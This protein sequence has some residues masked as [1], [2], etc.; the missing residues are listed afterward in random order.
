[1]V[2]KTSLHSWLTNWRKGG[3][4]VTQDSIKQ[5]HSYSPW[6]LP[7]LTLAPNDDATLY[8]SRHIATPKA[9]DIGVTHSG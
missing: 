2:P 9:L 5:H 4:V 8:A 7:L 6:Q 3:R 1:M